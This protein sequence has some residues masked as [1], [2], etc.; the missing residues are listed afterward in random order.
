MFPMFCG[1]KA[2]IVAIEAAAVDVSK[3]QFQTSSAANAQDGLASSWGQ[4]AFMRG[5]ADDASADIQGGC[6]H[7]NDATDH[8]VLDN[9]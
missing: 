2:V 1:Q 6:I 3:G 4:N 9:V 7:S 8:E 5:S